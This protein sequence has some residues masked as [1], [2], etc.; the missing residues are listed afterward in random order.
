MTNRV[1]DRS[2][3]P[4]SECEL[5][6]KIDEAQEEKEGH[7]LPLGQLK[8]STCRTNTVNKRMKWLHHPSHIKA[9]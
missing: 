8:H 5:D 4:T 2:K 9:D 1:R 7:A 3:A 6:D